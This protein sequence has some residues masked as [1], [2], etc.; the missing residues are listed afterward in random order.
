MR[1]QLDLNCFIQNKSCSLAK[2]ILSL[3]YIILSY[4]FAHFLIAF[5]TFR[6]SVRSRKLKYTLL[7][8][9]TLLFFL[10]YSLIFLG[11]E[12]G[13]KVGEGGVGEVGGG[14][15]GGG[16]GSGMILSK[17]SI[18]LPLNTFFFLILALFIDC[19]APFKKLKNVFFFEVSVSVVSFIGIITMQVG[20]QIIREKIGNR[21]NS[22]FLTSLVCT[23]INC[24]FSSVAKWGILMENKFL[25]V[26][27][28]YNIKI[29]L[30]SSSL[31]PPPLPPPSSLLSPHFFVVIPPLF[32]ISSILFFFSPLLSFSSSFL[33]FFLLLLAFFLLSS[34]LSFL[35]LSYFLLLCIPP[36][37][38]L[39]F[40]PS[41][42]LF[43]LIFLR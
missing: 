22:L 15:G 37:S 34:P 18:L 9:L 38:S 16:A 7:T 13:G 23:A 19:K 33:L 31:P 8:L 32:S 4:S 5:R 12:G 40:P 21:E 36:S 17:L 28:K 2:S 27:Q 30:L 10:S 24:I 14:G 25:N 42:F 29:H 26:S 11:I 39:F 3:P 1:R 43:L 35:S 41:F 6:K 20:F